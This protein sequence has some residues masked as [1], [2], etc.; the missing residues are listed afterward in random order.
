[1]LP[2]FS[3]V[4][5]AEWVCS[6]F[7]LSKTLPSTIKHLTEGKNSFAPNPAITTPEAAELKNPRV[8]R[9]SAVSVKWR[10]A[11]R[12]IG[13]FSKTTFLS[14]AI[15]RWY[16]F[17]NFAL[18]SVD[19]QDSASL[20]FQCAWWWCDETRSRRKS[21][22]VRWVTALS[23]LRQQTSYAVSQRQTVLPLSWWGAPTSGSEENVFHFSRHNGGGASR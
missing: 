6:Y 8:K 1:M 2:V 16:F 13:S 4:I 14:S 20:F 21:G 3:K 15:F 22:V 18:K 9:L 12:E 19:M 11:V 5:S 17:L 23:S 10:D 7:S